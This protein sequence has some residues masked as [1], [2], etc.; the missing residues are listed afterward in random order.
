MITIIIEKGG[1][2]WIR[3]PDAEDEFLGD[4]DQDVEIIDRGLE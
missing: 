3:R 4:I 2:V 1:L